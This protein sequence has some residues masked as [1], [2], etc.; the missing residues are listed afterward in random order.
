MDI[1]EQLL[2]YVPFNNQEIKDKEMILNYIDM[3]DDVL[4]RN[5]EIVHCTAS[6]LVLNEN[7]DKILMIYHNLYNSWGWPGG[8]VDGESNFLEV[9][10]REVREE[11]GVKEVKPLSQD[12]YAIDV[13][14]VL[15]HIKKGKYISAHI[16]ISIGYLLEVSEKEFLKIKPDENSNVGWLEIDKFLDK[17]T[18][19]HMKPIYLKILKKAEQT[20]LKTFIV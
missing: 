8:H 16:H 18:E 19:P 7:K 17:V 14:A 10:M 4:T 6:G 1:K 13:L 11:T 12:I 5:N 3:F 9:A 2:K 15:G 20:D